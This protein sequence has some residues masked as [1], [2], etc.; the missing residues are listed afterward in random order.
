MRLTTNIMRLTTVIMRLATVIM[1]LTT[2]ISKRL[3][4][5]LAPVYLRRGE[6]AKGTGSMQHR[7]EQTLY[8]QACRHA[9]S[10]AHKYRCLTHTRTRTQ[11]HREYHRISR[12][13]NKRYLQD[14]AGDAIVGGKVWE[15][16]VQVRH[17][18]SEVGNGC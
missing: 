6:L 17:G 12:A 15:K 3:V 7:E 13:H 9:R 16:R 10:N 8:A 4:T 1:Q 14:C 18:A 11:I 2:V 5:V